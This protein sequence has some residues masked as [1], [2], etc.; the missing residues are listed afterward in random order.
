MTVKTRFAPEPDRLPAHRRRPDRALSWLYARHHGGSFVLRIEDT[1]RER[2]TQA[3]VDAILDGMAWLGLDPDEG[4]FFQTDHGALS[5]LADRMLREGSAYRCYCSKA[6][7]EVR[8]AQQARGE[9]PRYDGRCRERTSAVPGADS[10]IRF[11][12]PREVTVVDDLI[13]GPVE[14]SNAELDD[15]SSCVRTARRPSTSAWWSTT[16]TWASPTSSAAT[17]T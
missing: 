8:A 2:S 14:F 1:D 11:R 6:E 10:V 9:N 17:I 4:P 12:T 16:A 7:L 3:A 5:R 13:R 15:R